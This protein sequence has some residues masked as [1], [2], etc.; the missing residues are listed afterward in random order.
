[1]I[2]DEFKYG[3]KFYKEGKS[4]KRTAWYFLN[5]LGNKNDQVSCSLFNAIYH[6]IGLLRQ[7]GPLLP[8]PHSRKFKGRKQKIREL[9]LKHVTGY[10]RI[11]YCPW[12]SKT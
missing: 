10:H 6:Q 4:T 11:F 3:I 1:M 12:V 9:R 5:Q 7:L 2:D 8:M